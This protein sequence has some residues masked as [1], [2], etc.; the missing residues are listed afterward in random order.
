MIEFTKFC[1]YIDID[2]VKIEINTCH[3]YAHLYKSYGP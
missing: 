3:F 1:I 2:K